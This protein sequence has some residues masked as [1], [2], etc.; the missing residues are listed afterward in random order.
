VKTWLDTLAWDV[1]AVTVFLW[2]LR[3]VI[4]FIRKVGEERDDE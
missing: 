1:L 3:S 2:L 4:R